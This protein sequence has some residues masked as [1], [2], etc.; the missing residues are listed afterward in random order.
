[1]KKIASAQRLALHKM[2]STQG[3]EH[4]FWTSV[5]VK[6]LRGS[7]GR[8]YL[9]DLPRL[10][11][12]DVEWL[13]K[14]MGSGD[15]SYPH[16]VVLLRPE[17]L[18]TFWEHSLKVWARQVQ[19]EKAQ[20]EKAEKEGS[21]ATEGEDAK[22]VAEDNP[23]EPASVAASS[24]SAVLDV[25]RKF[26]L[27]FNADA[28]VEQPKAFG[29][30]KEVSDGLSYVP[31]SQKDETDPS[32][33]AVR[34]A[35]LFVRN[36]AVPAML[37]DIV[38]SNTFGVMDGVSLSKQMH[39]RGINMRYLGLLMDT[40][41]KT[42]AGPEVETVGLL[43]AMKIIVQQ[44]MVFRACKHILRRLMHGLLA[45]HQICAVSHFLNCLLG[46]QRNANPAAV[47][48]PLDFAK[49]A[50]P[51]YVKLTP[52]SLRAEIA[53]EVQRRFRWKLDE[54]SLMTGLKRPQLLRELAT[55]IAFQLQQRTYY[56]EAMEREDASAT[57]SE[58]DKE[59]VAPKQAKKT[60]AAK[61]IDEGSTRANTFEPCDIV[62]LL[63]VI[64]SCAPTVRFS[65]LGTA[66]NL[67][68]PSSCSRPLSPRSCS[69]PVTTPSTTATSLLVSN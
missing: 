31:E 17:L 50:D 51:L 23:A 1:M 2:Q 62:A 68:D 13:E 52:Q 21:A 40:I 66:L 18:E 48:E 6:G 54:E 34:D 63:P 11:L 5:D 49:T 10:S 55:R 15:E 45:E 20:K 42:L 26:E 37:I 46:S 59:N 28:F 8:R 56:Y 29:E 22:P 65:P 33:K 25:P 30:A 12:V 61:V 3:E 57:N 64:K 67:A 69:K 35:S 16:R 36:I 58:E 43:K 4:E 47:Y 7:D 32:I 19:A 38:T 39:V 9:L 27:R 44:E 24:S 53:R 14:D 41:E 60:K